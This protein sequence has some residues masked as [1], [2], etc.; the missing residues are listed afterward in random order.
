MAVK[1]IAGLVY[2]APTQADGVSGTPLTGILDDQVEFEDGLT[3]EAH[4]SGLEADAWTSV[5]VPGN[6][7]AIYLPLQDVSA[8]T[9][10]LL[11]MLRSTGTGIDSAAGN[12]VGLYGSPPGYSLVIRPRASAEATYWY[13]PRV[14]IDAQRSIVRVT[15]SRLGKRHSAS[16]LVLYPRRSADGTKKAW[17]EGTHTAINTYYGLPV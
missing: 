10:K 9:N 4:G 5:V 7:P 6:R 16:A 1:S 8:E 3:D 17:M 15:W 11:W 12:G 2:L 13:F 14:S